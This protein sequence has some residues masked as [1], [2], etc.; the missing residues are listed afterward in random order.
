MRQGRIYVALATSL[1]ING[2]SATV[3]DNDR[4][5][6]YDDVHD[7]A[8]FW[9]R[10]WEIVGEMKGV[11]FSGARQE[12]KECTG[13]EAVKMFPPALTDAI[14]RFVANK[15]RG[16]FEALLP[17]VN[18]FAS[19]YEKSYGVQ[20]GERIGQICDEKMKAA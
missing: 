6:G 7:A 4:F 19:A 1:A 13:N 8:S 10:T 17:M 16:N 14:E 18:E 3:P 15:T 9:V 2:C 20:P 11:D 5:P 12:F